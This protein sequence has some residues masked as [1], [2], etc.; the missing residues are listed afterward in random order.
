MENEFDVDAH[1]IPGPHPGTHNIAKNAVATRRRDT[2]GRGHVTP[3][4]SNRLRRL[5]I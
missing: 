5:P 1:I 4:G 3:S 2:P